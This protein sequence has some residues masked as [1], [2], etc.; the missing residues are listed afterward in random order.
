MTNPLLFNNQILLA[1]LE[2]TFGADSVPTGADAVKCFPLSPRFDFRVLDYPVVRGSISAPKRRQGAK[3]IEF[4]IRVPLKGSGT[5]GTAPE[6]GPLAQACRHKETIAAGVSVTYSPTPKADAVKSVSIYHY[7]DGKVVK[8]VGCRGNVRLIANAGNYGEL[9]F[10]MRGRMTARADAANP[11]PT[12]DATEPPVIQSGGVSFGSFHT[13]VI[14]ALSLN[15]GNSMFDEENINAAEGITGSSMADRDPTWNA[16]VR[17]TLEDTKAWWGNADAGTEEAIDLTVG[18]TAGNI[19]AVAIPKA[20]I[21]GGTE[22]QN[23]NGQVFYNLE[24]QCN[25]TSADDNYSIALT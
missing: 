15:S 14:P 3:M 12:Y 20:S 22:P 17:A 23:K 18:A 25:E 5:A 13:A 1:K 16:E 19:I 7:Q 9:E 4:V 11:T 2:D 24:G 10:T 21:S 8:A 6:W